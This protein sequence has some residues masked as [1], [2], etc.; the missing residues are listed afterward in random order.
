M[1]VIWVPPRLKLAAAMLVLC[2]PIAA[3]ETVIVARAPW[4]RLP[5]R[6][7]EVW[8]VGVMVGCLPLMAWILRGRAWALPVTGAFATLWCFLSGWVAI[9]TRNSTLGFFVLFLV[10]FWIVLLSWIRFELGQSFLDPKLRWFQA[11]PKPIPWLECELQVGQA[12]LPMR[13]GRIDEEG[14]FVFSNLGQIPRLS[15]ADRIA[16]RLTYRGREAV[17]GAV[18]VCELASGQGIGLRFEG[19]TADQ[20]KNLGD[21]VEVL[22]G[23]GHV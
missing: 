9:R 21:F 4:W 18:P 16:L 20:R 3:M 2:V 7:I 13:V 5:Y 14:L 12:T 17:G 10:F 8:S 15:R 6:T 19:M 22:R 1:R 11:L 23:E